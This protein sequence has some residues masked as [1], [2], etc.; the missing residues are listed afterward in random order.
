MA[1]TPSL[2]PATLKSISQVKS[3]VAIRSLSTMC[4]VI[5]SSSSWSVIS[6][7]A[8][9]A[10]GF[11]IGT[12]ASISANVEPQTDHIDVEPPDPKHSDTA[13]MV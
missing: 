8:I 5:L 3:S 12:H 13:L 6:P 1:V 4:L 11:L 9:P 7:I 2:V 10:T